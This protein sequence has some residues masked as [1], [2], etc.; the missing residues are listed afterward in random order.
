MAMKHKEGKIAGERDLS[1][2]WQAWLPDG[3]AKATVVIAHGL[4]EHGGR[5]QRVGEYLV[6][7]GFA[8]YAIDHRGHG[9]SE[10]GR[11][12]VDH[13]D[14]AVAD[15][16]KLVDLARA[17][18]PDVPLFL[19]GH[20]MGGALS[21]SYTLNHQEK[22]DGLLLSGPAVSLDGASTAT[23][24]ISKILSFLTPSLGL[25]GVDPSVVSRDPVEVAAYDKDPLNFHG[26]VPAR[27]VGEI[28]NF[29][30]ML[31]GRLAEITLP[32]LL[33]HG[34][35][36]KL[37]GISGSEMV[38][39]GIKSKDKTLKRYTGLYHE[40]FNEFPD[41][42]ARVFADMGNWLDAHVG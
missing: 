33:M 1:I 16:D 3:K 23:Q 9:K 8:A 34:T 11:A 27:T 14:N 26:K 36:D 29:V 5:Y 40:I 7:Q 12:L 28:V 13:F 19:L 42:R 38:L 22:L 18:R 30:G 24:V 17:A 41:D 32:V 39:K 21:L 2:Y 20:S 25:F 15:M 37:A 10:G 6:Q 35:D 31:P 4:G